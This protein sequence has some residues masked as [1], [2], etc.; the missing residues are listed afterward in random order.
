MTTRPENDPTPLDPRTLTRVLEKA[1]EHHMNVWW[2]HRDTHSR[3][4]WIMVNCS[5]LF[6]WGTAD[7]VTIPPPNVDDFFAT[8]AETE[9]LIDSYPA[10]R[11]APDHTGLL[12]CARQRGA[13]PQGAYYEHLWDPDEMWF[14]LFDAVADPTPTGFGNPASA[15]VGKEAARKRQRGLEAKGKAPLRPFE[16]DAQPPAPQGGPLDEDTLH[17]VLYDLARMDAA[18][19]TTLA[20]HDGRVHVY[21]ESGNSTDFVEITPNRASLLRAIAD[22]ADVT[23]GTR[24]EWAA[25]VFIQACRGEPVPAWLAQR[26]REMEPEVFERVT[27]RFLP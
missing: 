1:A 24:G 27:R 15:E 13:Q 14:S 26:M 19:D 10:M 23:W 8:C 18:S 2:R 20:L 7:C 25:A 4:L 11:A 6:F 3:D 17:G 9:A 22:E 12:F 5:D 16:P 21:L